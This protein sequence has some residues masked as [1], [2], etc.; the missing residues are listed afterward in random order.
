MLLRIL[1]IHSTCG[2]AKDRLHSFS[3]SP[4]VKRRL[5]FLLISLLSGAVPC[6]PAY[7]VAPP[8]NARE[9]RHRLGLASSS[10]L[11]CFTLCFF[12]IDETIINH[13]GVGWPR[14]SSLISYLHPVASPPMLDTRGETII[15]LD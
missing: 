5:L 3:R 15:E 14:L 9:T 6:G 1:H 2:I 11:S 10:M 12:P 13:P 8:F 4:R 7:P